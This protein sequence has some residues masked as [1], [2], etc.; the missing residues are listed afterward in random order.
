MTEGTF[1]QALCAWQ[2]QHGRHHLPWQNTRDPY[3]IWVSEVMLQ[4]TQVTTVLNYYQRFM[5]RFPS[6]AAL[7]EAPLDDVLSHW[8][9]LGYYSRA[10]HL[11]QAATM[12]KARG[13]LPKTPAEWSALP[14]IGRSTAAAI[15]VFSQGQ[16]VAIL[17]GN[18]K[19]ILMRHFALPQPSS[20]MLWTLA[21]DLVPHHDIESYTQGLMDLGSLVCTR[22]R[23]HC[24]QCPFLHSCASCAT[25]Q[26][27]NPQPIRVKN[28]RPRLD[29]RLLLIHNA[30]GQWLVT[31]RPMQGIWAGLWTFPEEAC[32]PVLPAGHTLGLERILPD[33]VRL[34]PFVH[35]LTHREWH[36]HPLLL[37]VSPA[38]QQ[39]MNPLS[40]S[41]LTTDDIAKRAIPSPVRNLLSILNSIRDE[42]PVSIDAFQNIAPKFRPD[43]PNDAAHRYTPA[44]PSRPNGYPE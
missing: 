12:L 20:A 41:W 14:G 13:S 37:Q 24:S 9:G 4:Q 31:Q 21:E 39:A 15:A 43:K 36:F 27:I 25:G 42:S 17:D 1:S 11:H 26:F 19:R 23:P 6:I 7:S 33:A 22:Q 10:R 8:S 34:V 2:K 38:V 30:E 18:V 32:D 16:R 28:V 40:A 3:R 44:P 5:T 29:S 35:H